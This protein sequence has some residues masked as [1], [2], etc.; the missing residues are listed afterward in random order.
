LKSLYYYKR[1]KETGDLVG[2]ASQGH[3][4]VATLILLN[5]NLDQISAD[6]KFILEQVLVKTQS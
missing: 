1:T 6:Y 3:K 4:A 2:K 5:N